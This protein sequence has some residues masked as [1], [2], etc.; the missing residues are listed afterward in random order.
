LFGS[1]SSRFAA[2]TIPPSGYAARKADRVPTLAQ[3]GGFAGHES[4]PSSWSD[5]D[6][7]T[8]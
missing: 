1:T 2:I 5:F 7:T 6:F 8:W 4:G 3:E